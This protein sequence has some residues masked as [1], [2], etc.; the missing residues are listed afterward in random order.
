MKKKWRLSSARFAFRSL[1]R[2]T[3]WLYC[4]NSVQAEST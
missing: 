2:S 4:L 3:A 1:Y